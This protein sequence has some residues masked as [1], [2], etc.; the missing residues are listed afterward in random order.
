MAHGLPFL[1]LILKTDRQT[2]SSPLDVPR[3]MIYF[4]TPGCLDHYLKREIETKFFQIN[5]K[6]YRNKFFQILMCV[7]CVWRRVFQNRYYCYEFINA[8]LLVYYFGMSISK[9]PRNLYGLIL[10][11]SAN[12][13][14]IYKYIIYKKV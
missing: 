11:S 5:N 4:R 10:K 2:R 12:Y 14:I 7:F 9:W 3:M 6:N 8:I 13:I 1:L